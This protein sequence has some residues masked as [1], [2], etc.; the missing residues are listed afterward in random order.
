[1]HTSRVPTHQFFQGAPQCP[2]LICRERNT[3]VTNN[4]ILPNFLCTENPFLINIPLRCFTGLMMPLTPPQTHRRCDHIHLPYLYLHTSTIHKC[5]PVIFPYLPYL[6]SAIPAISLYLPYPFIS[7]IFRISAS[8]CLLLRNS[9]NTLQ[10]ESA[11][12]N[13]LQARQLPPYYASL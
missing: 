8:C 6:L 5:L 11:E 7:H 4:K 3:L 10:T 12:N 1:L 13:A 2:S 9:T